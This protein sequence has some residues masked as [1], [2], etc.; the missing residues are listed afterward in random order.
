MTFLNLLRLIVEIIEPTFFLT[1]CSHLS[2]DQW[3]GSD[4]FLQGLDLSGGASE[5]GGSRVH[6]G[7]AA[8]F[9]QSQLTA[10]G[11]S[12]SQTEKNKTIK[13]L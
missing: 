7:L 4:G 10:H 11:Q 9:T 12:V 13:K 5:Q 3:N 6:D 1:P 2:L 8:A